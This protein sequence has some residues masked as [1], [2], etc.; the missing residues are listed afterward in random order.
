MGID[1]QM[2]LM[3]STIKQ[4][5]CKKSKQGT[6]PQ[7]TNKNNKFTMKTLL[8]YP[9]FLDQRMDT[10]DIMAPPIGMY[11]VGATLLE[12]G[13]EV[14]IL[15]WFN[16]P[17]GPNAFMQAV[18]EEQPDIIGFSMLHANRWGAIDMA[19]EAKQAHPDITII[20]GGV[21][22]TFLWQHLLTH[23][24]Q[25]DYVI[26]G[27]GEYAF[28]QLLGLMEQDRTSELDKIR[29]LA[30]RKNGRPFHTGPPSPVQD[31]DLL[32]NPARYFQY[33]HVISSRGCPWSCSFCGSPRFW[34]RKVRFH[35]PKYFVDQLE[36]LYKKGISF[37]YVSD[38]TFTIK[39]ERVIQICQDIIE[40]KLLITW[41]AISRVGYVDEEILYWMRKAGCIQISY[42]VESG[43]PKIRQ[44]L[45][46][47]LKDTDIERAFSLTRRYGILPRAYFI[48][49]C[50]G[51]T[52]TT[53]EE[54]LKLISKIR[55]LSIIFYILDI[56]PGTTLY[57]EFKKKSGLTD[58]I[59][60][61]RIEDIMYFETDPQLTQEMV[62]S[63]G[64]T[65]RKNYFAKLHE[66][67][68]DIDL[69]EKEDLYPLHAD[70]L[71]RLGMTFS[72]GDYS[73]NPHVKDKDKVAEMLFKRALT[74]YPNERAYLGLAIL[75]QKAGK[76]QEAIGILSEAVHHYPG[77][78]QLN[79][80][81][82]ISHMNLG[83]FQKAIGHLEAFSHSQNALQY[84]A[85]CYAAIGRKD[86]E[87]ECLERL[88]SKQ[89]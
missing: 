58:D 67:A 74:Y 54:T 36:T 31:L 26:T 56:F 75:K 29:G 66:F 5:Y 13:H 49:G 32:P 24:P 44:R 15:N 53:V 60:L 57:E 82:A 8:V 88:N 65:L 43:S 42:G 76:H 79:T 78:E 45:N 35:S 6:F 63:F 83:D 33:N 62:L 30:F 28:A 12:R 64:Q 87:R 70:F 61:Q 7:K 16:M 71:S 2:P 14:K 81:L 86:K 9:P 47:K 19:K 89:L 38:D 22:A 55:P 73:R 72:H 18:K 1:R 46:K 40:R 77:S 50:P 85:R 25:I 84:L 51:E 52:D 10:E 59:W 11:Y 37:F 34:G 3:H 48:Y 21:G 17:K 80:C 69:V 27:E 23:F 68:Q 20:C 39:K 41:Q 4:Y